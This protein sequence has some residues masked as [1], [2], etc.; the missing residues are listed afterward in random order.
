MSLRVVSHRLES[1]AAESLIVR[2]GTDL[3]HQIGGR[4]AQL[5]V[6]SSLVQTFERLVVFTWFE[7]KLLIHPGNLF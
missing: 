1:L 6:L 4:N 7:I 5:S 2:I 3:D